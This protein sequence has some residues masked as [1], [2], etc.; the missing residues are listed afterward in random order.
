MDVVNYSKARKN[1][2]GLMDRVIDDSEE[3]AISRSTG[4]SVVMVS[5]AHYNSIIE[6]MHLFST[7]TNARRLRESTAQLDAGECEEREIIDP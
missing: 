2:N 1:L 7:P 3:I 4:D 6:T 5:L